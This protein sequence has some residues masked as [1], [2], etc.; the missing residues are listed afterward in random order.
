ML[1]YIHLIQE[2]EGRRKS[3]VQNNA[4]AYIPGKPVLSE[5]MLHN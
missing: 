3:P 5:E 2:S 1:I 4:F